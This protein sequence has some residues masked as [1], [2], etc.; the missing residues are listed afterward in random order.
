MVVT[1]ATI[2]GASA[3][4]TAATPVG[5]A[6]GP[7]A[8]AIGSGFG[9]YKGGRKLYKYVH[10]KSKA[11]DFIDGLEA[12]D[13]GVEDALAELGILPPWCRAEIRTGHTATV[14]GRIRS[15]LKQ[16]RQRMAEG[17]FLA[18]TKGSDEER[19][20]ARTILLE[21]YKVKSKYVSAAE[22]TGDRA[23]VEIVKSK[24]SSW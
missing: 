7:C 4:V 11:R 8:A 16:K 1:T 3:V 15:M 18:L 14:Q 13:P 12:G 5:W 20:Q 22:G 24:L 10:Y 17:I 19:A 6:L 23:T 9:I 2:L 21:G